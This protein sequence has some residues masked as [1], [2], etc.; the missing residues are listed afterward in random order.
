MP[1]PMQSCL[2]SC[3]I[4]RGR[5]N[6]YHDFVVQVE[7]LLG[8]LHWCSLLSEVPK[9]LLAR[10]CAFLGCALDLAVQ[11]ALEQ[12]TFQ[13]ASGDFSTQSCQPFFSLHP[14]SWKPFCLDCERQTAQQYGE[15]EKVKI[16]EASG[17]RRMSPDFHQCRRCSFCKSLAHQCDF[18][19]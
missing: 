9:L 6:C 1:F 4:H 15:R 7:A 2:V 16:Q 17:S 18:E 19:D 11:V 3:K 5:Y 13:L 10:D 8:R 12:G 14:P